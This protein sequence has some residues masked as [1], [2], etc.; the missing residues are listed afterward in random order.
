MR[1]HNGKA[2]VCRMRICVKSLAVFTTG[3]EQLRRSPPFFFNA[4]Q[5][6][7]KEYVSRQKL[8]MTYK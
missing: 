5:H 4:G 6:F 3:Q 7:R 2:P 8:L 1:I